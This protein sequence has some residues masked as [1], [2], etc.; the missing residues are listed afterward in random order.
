MRNALVTPVPPSWIVVQL[1][2]S[3]ALSIVRVV[4]LKKATLGGTVVGHSGWRPF[5]AVATLAY[6][7]V[8]GLAGPI[9]PRGPGS[10]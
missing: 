5:L 8:R 9:G 10:P 7:A 1:F 3:V 4:L 2:V 6:I